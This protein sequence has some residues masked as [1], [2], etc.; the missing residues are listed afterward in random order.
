MLEEDVTDRMDVFLVDGPVDD[1]AAAA[2]MGG[3]ALVQDAGVSKGRQMVV[4]VRA[5]QPER[6]HDVVRR[7]VA[8]GHDVPE[9]P[10]PSW[11]RA[12]SDT[13]LFEGEAPVRHGHI[14]RGLLALLA[15]FDT[16][17]NNRCSLMNQAKGTTWAQIRGS[18]NGYWLPE[19]GR[20]GMPR[21]ANAVLKMW[22]EGER[23]E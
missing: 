21:T 13:G 1:R 22:N 2:G 5:G 7:G 10:Q 23:N 11:S 17:A 4:N 8:M 16:I 6:F 15:I 3:S 18:R 20:Q 19:S 14:L 9:G 12:N